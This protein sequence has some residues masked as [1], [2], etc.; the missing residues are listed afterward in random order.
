MEDEA[1]ISIEDGV[2][3]AV[4]HIRT[5]FNKNPIRILKTISICTLLD[6]RVDDIIEKRIM[7][8]GY[9]LQRTDKSDIMCELNKILQSDNVFNGLKMLWK[10]RI[11]NFIIPELAI[12]WNYDQ[13]SKYHNLQLWEH[14]ARVVESAQKNMEPINILMTCLL[15]D[16]GKPF[17][18]TDKWVINNIKKVNPLGY[19]IN[20]NAE[21]GYIK[22]NYVHHES[23]GANLAYGILK[24]LNFT[25]EDTISIV[26]L[27]RGHLNDDSIIRVYDNAHKSTPK[28]L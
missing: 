9:L 24:R 13:N 20:N 25:K 11:F 21:D 28:N 5:H 23:V 4:G 3:H 15:H 27:I 19:N 2:L 22:T 17:V 12:Q 8:M 18:R 14:T 26:R 6:V 16:V 7:D 10:Y 1:W